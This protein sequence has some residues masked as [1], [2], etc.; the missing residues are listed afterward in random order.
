MMLGL[1]AVEAETVAAVA[2]VVAAAV[3]ITQTVVI[4]VAARL[5][6]RQV[7]AAREQVEEARRLREE[8]SRPFVVV[9][10]DISDPP[11]VF[12]TV[13]NVGRTI[14]RRVRINFDPPLARSFDNRALTEE[15]KKAGKP[16]PPLV[17]YEV[18]NEEIASI[19]PGKVLRTLFE[20]FMQGWREDLPD[21]YLVTVRYED[22]RGVSYTEDMPMGFG[23][24]KN[25]EDIRRHTIHDLHDQL[26]K[27]ADAVRR[28]SPATGSGVLV[29]SRKEQR[30]DHARAV[31]RFRARPDASFAPPRSSE[32]RAQW[33]LRR[34][35]QRLARTL[36][37]LSDGVDPEE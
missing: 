14:A 32:P 26:K 13:S 36:A 18:F 11:L 31:R 2:A 10:L 4:I 23:G 12:L 19:A 34:Q 22:E 24:F 16:L 8:Q 27:I 30:E 15:E 7:V 20:S 33:E 6:Y 21:S 5:T 17:P 25:L 35:R 28:W 3:G 9:D 1:L 37:A 29:V